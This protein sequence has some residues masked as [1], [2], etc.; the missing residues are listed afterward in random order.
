MFNIQVINVAI[1]HQEVA[2]NF[3]VQ[4]EEKWILSER[5]ILLDRE[6]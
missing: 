3:D 5:S 2:L 4:V 6:H 1:D